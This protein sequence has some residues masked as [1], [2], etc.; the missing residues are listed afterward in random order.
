MERK[1]GKISGYFLDYTYQVRRNMN[2]NRVLDTEWRTRKQ[3]TVY[4]E[5]D[6]FVCLIRKII[7][8]FIPIA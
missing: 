3:H 1:Y 7:G 5:T 6:E 2:P 8:Y 4:E